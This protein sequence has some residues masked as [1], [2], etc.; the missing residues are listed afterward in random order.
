[1]VGQGRCKNY[2][3]VLDGKELVVS[4][5]EQELRRAWMG[6]LVELEHGMKDSVVSSCWQ[7]VSSCWQGVSSLERNSWELSSLVEQLVNSCLVRRL[8]QPKTSYK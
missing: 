7:V 4:M 6:S 5:Q 2:M 1:M 8:H 3:M